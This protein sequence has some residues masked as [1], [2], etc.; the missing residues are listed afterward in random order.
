MNFQSVLARLK[1]VPPRHL[2]IAGLALVVAGAAV[3]RR[4]GPAQE[5]A[6]G[7][8]LSSHRPGGGEVGPPPAAL[9]QVLGAQPKGAPPE[10]ARDLF[11]PQREA[12]PGGEA[13]AA[14]VEL[15][16]TA[17][18]LSPQGRVAILSGQAVGEGET[19]MGA[20]VVRIDEGS[21]EL[22]SGGRK[23]RLNVCP[24]REE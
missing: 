23:V 22:E 13:G 18:M 20:R 5:A 7:L 15:V 21:V 9:P 6:P 24:L 10:L 2:L 12:A 4:S 11:E 17:T 19:V 8:A 14:P 3:V 16:L 1:A